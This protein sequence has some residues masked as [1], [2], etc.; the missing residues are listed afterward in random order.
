M[1]IRRPLDISSPDRA[2]MVNVLRASS[3]I[4]N[5]S[6]LK[7][8]LALVHAACT[9]SLE[10]IH[11][12]TAGQIAERAIK[13]YGIE[14]TASFTGQAFASLGIGTVTSHGKNRFVLEHESLET[15]RQGIAS[16]I[17][18]MAERLEAS[19]K[20]FDILPEKIKALES[21]WQQIVQLRNKEQELSVAINEA[22]K[23]PSK[24]PY[25]EQEVR[26]IQAEAARSE[27]LQEDI[28]ELSRQIKKLPLLEEKKKALENRIKEF[29]A[30]TGELNKREQQIIKEEQ[31][32]SEKESSLSARINKLRQR[33]GWVDWAEV[34]EAIE[35]AKKELDQILRQL[36]E[37][38]SLL[39]KLLLRNKGMEKK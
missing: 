3:S 21:Q 38:R 36:G 20:T 35:T 16:Q 13:D 26:K 2:E 9:F 37:K 15:I 12:V 32:L 30:K 23:T 14:A 4:R 10:G 17:E 6:E 29:E 7:V 24:L 31:A 11:R 22:R 5:L 34:E 27:K 19:L 33:K 28:K 39:D 8:S 25:L 1:I 18:T